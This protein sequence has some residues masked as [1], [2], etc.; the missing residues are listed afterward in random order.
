MKEISAEEL[1]RAVMQ[2][3]DCANVNDEFLAI[4]EKINEVFPDDSDDIKNRSYVLLTVSKAA[5]ERWRNKGIL[6]HPLMQKALLQ[7]FA[8]KL[9]GRLKDKV[10]SPSWIN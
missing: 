9:Y 1:Y 6:P 4:L 2:A 8:Q 3:L 10:P 5:W 7:G